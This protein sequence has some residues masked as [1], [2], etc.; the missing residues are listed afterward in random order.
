MMPGT[1]RVAA[2]RSWALLDEP[3]RRLPETSRI[4]VG[5]LTSRTL[6]G[7]ARRLSGR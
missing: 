6:A 3:P 7:A 2:V 1:E 4:A 5:G